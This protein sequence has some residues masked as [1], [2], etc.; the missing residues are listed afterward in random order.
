MQNMRSIISTQSVIHLPRV[1]C[2]HGKLTSCQL[3]FNTGSFIKLEIIHSTQILAFFS[4]AL[5]KTTAHFLS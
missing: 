3:V 2:N 5:L 4:F 1:Q